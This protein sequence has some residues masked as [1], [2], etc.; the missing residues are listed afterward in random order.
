MTWNLMSVM[1]KEVHSM[2]GNIRKNNEKMGKIFF[3][4]NFLLIRKAYSL[5]VLCF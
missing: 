5:L 3:R 2:D 4:K 1:M